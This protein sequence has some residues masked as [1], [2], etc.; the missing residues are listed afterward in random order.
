[1]QRKDSH[2]PAATA[3][4][5]QAPATPLRVPREVLDQLR[6]GTTTL[7]RLD[8]DGLLVPLRVGGKVRRYTQSSIDAYLASIATNTANA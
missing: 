7:R 3:A 1:M 5:A 2:P 4:P 6:I 8:R